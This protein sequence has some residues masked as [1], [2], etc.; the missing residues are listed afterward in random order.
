[1]SGEATSIKLRRPPLSAPGR[2]RSR[3][4]GGDGQLTRMSL[5][6]RVAGLMLGAIVA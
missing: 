1:M 5:D 4:R 3:R 2:L 6:V